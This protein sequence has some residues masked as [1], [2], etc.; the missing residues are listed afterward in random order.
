MNDS[1]D[2]LR[3]LPK[4]DILLSE[5][6]VAANIRLL[7]HGQVADLCRRAVSDAKAR[8]LEDGVPP[9]I[10]DI[11]AAIAGACQ[12]ARAR[13]LGRVVNGTGVLLHTNL[14]R[15]PLGDRLFDELRDLAS[16]YCNVE[17]NVLERRR[18]VRGEG[19]VDL[20]KQVCGAEDAVVVNNNAAALYLTLKAL[21]EG[22]EVVVSRGELVQIGG[23]FRIPDILRAAG[24]TLREVGTTNITSSRDYTDAVGEETA[25]VLS[26]HRANFRMEGFVESPTIAELKRAVPGVP[27][28]A[29]LG[30]GNLMRSIGE[31]AIPEPT[32]EDMLRAG[33]DL[34]CFSADK[35]LGGVQ[36]GIIAGRAEL[37]AAVR[38]HPVMRVVRPHKLIYGAL[39]ILLEKYLAGEA[40]EAIRLWSLAAASRESL[41]ERAARFIEANAL[42]REVFSVVDCESA[43]GGGSAP[44]FTFA[45]AGLLVSGG[46]TADAVARFFQTAEPPVIGTVRAEGLVIDFRTVLEEDEAALAGACR[47]LQQTFE[48]A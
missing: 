5:P 8:A 42:R 1:N 9:E 13:R 14:G 23:G 16:G 25:V 43:F 22:R 2:L 44:E 45:S 17:I 39:Q 3:R 10:S 11:V 40:P 7:G 47:K 32:P 29:D 19:V 37:V 26:V 48:S 30:S 28:V 38:R 27:L 12:R 34:V 20:L 21:A 6:E 15:A 4:I 18:G 31:T 36:G 24:A 33:A 46:G 35:M 41:R